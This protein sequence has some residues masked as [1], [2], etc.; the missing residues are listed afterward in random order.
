[1]PAAR[2]RARFNCIYLRRFALALGLDRHRL[3]SGDA[4]FVVISAVGVVV[5]LGYTIR[6]ILQIA[7]TQARLVD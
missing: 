5:A 6:A 1:M 3:A 7:R 2:R 4:T